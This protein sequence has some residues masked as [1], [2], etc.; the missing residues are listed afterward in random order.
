MRAVIC[1]TFGGIDALR[2]G[3]IEPP[4][5]GPGQVAIAV[6]AAG[7]NYADTLIVAG[8]YQLKPE[9]PFTPGMEIAG[10]VAAVGEGVDHLAPG[11]RVLAILDH[12]GFAETALARADDVFPIPDS[13]DFAPAAGFAVTYGTAHGALVWRAGLQRGETLLVHGAAGGAGLA[14]VEVGKV[15][16][17]RVIATAG[18]L[19]KLAVAR[20]HGADYG[21]DYRSEDVRTRV[22]ELTDGLGAD[23]VYDP[24]GGKVFDA[25]LR[26]T[27]WGG[28]IVIIGFASGKVPAPPANLLLVKN[29]A[30][31]G[32]YW[33]SYREKA[34]HLMRQQFEDLFRWHGEGRLRPYVSH[35]LPLEHVT[36]A[37]RLLQDRRSTGKVVLTVD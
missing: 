10:T 35:T 22:K 19:E 13:L 28:R 34:P 26:C 7:V 4:R 36:E 20:E 17:A 37:L 9:L 6:A 29:L 23:V 24:V 11:T 18:G 12:G 5:P 32:F 1:D 16:G 27:A 8:K 2:V 15:L 25:S 3:E 30:V 14:G 31:L 21:I 33:G